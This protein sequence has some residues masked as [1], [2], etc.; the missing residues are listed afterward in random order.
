VVSAKPVQTP[1]PNLERRHAGRERGIAA[2]SDQ[3]RHL[4]MTTNE[5]PYP[6]GNYY[7]ELD[8]QDNGNDQDIGHDELAGTDPAAYLAFQYLSELTNPICARSRREDDR[9][10]ELTEPSFYLPKQRERQ[11][12]GYHEYRQ[13]R[14]GRRINP[15]TGYINWGEST[16]TGL[17]EVDYETYRQASELY[18][19][20]REISLINLDEYR[21]YRDRVWHDPQYNSHGALEQFIRF[22]RDRE[23]SPDQ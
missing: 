11:T 12:V 8:D 15:E 17:P 18:L 16:S 20:E 4:S 3:Q 14:H 7:G 23:P 19:Q 21:Q 1:A 9:E 10:I 2:S 22:V 6:R 5:S 13:H